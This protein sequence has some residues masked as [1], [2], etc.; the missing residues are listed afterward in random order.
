MEHAIEERRHH[1]AQQRQRS[2]AVADRRHLA[3][4]LAAEQ[5]FRPHHETADAAPVSAHAS[6]S[7]KSFFWPFE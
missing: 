5:R 1:A 4:E 7:R 3:V 2:L 6:A